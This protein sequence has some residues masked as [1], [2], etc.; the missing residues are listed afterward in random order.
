[1]FYGDN[2]LEQQINMLFNKHDYN[3]S[4]FLGVGELCGFLNDLF[5]AMGQS[6][7]INDQYQAQ[8]LLMQIDRNCDGKASRKEVR[9]MYQHVL[10]HGAQYGGQGK[11]FTI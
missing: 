3:R 5:A 4:G 10:S 8:Q 7:R 2:N 6:F 11:P 1:M 9:L